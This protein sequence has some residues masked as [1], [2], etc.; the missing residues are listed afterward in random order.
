MY[1]SLSNFF[2][3]L[4]FFQ[5]PLFGILALIIVGSSWCGVGLVMGH[6][7][8][9]GVEPSLVQLLGGIVSLLAG[10][11]IFFGTSCTTT[12]TLKVILL[13]GLTSFTAAIVN[14]CMLQLLSKAM[15]N[16]PNGVIWSMTQSS[17][18]IPF[19]TG[20][21]FFNVAFTLT[22]CMGIIALLFALLFF[23]LAKNNKPKG[24]KNN[25]WKYQAMGCF[26]L[27]GTTQ[28]L[29]SLPSYFPEAREV[30]SIL[31]AMAGASGSFLMA[32]SYNLARMTPEH[33]A[34]IFASFRKPILWIYVGVLQFFGLIF[35]YT[36]L[37]PGMDVLGKNNM[38]AISYPLLVGSCI[39]S[40]AIAG[41]FLLKEDFTFWQILALSFC[42]GGL[43]L[44]CL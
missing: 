32:I 11:V 21:I 7:P 18:L 43:F 2:A 30:P 38:G 3:E 40:F 29:S 14:F 28:T 16:G 15:Q 4:P 9:K 19:L 23:G 27:A 1:Q 24:E 13:T 39:A 22:R 5:S 10:T 35:A 42:F 31:R 17:L 20:I 12:A 44:I 25:I 26:F 6:A 37:Y 8:K 41:K 36:L 33:K 34:K